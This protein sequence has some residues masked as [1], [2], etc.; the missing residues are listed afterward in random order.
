MKDKVRYVGMDVHKL[1]I[2]MALADAGCRRSPGR[3]ER[4]TLVAVVGVTGL[5][6][7]SLR[8]RG[9]NRGGEDVWVGRRDSGVLAA[10]WGTRTWL[11]TVPISEDRLNLSR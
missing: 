3:V 10:G 9:R 5:E 8:A 11:A 2:T 7:V 6:P 4:K 1:T